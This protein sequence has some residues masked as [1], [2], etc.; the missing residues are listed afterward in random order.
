MCV[1]VCVCVFV[2]DNATDLPPSFLS[3]LF[4]FL[5]FF[6]FKVRNR[7]FF[8]LQQQSFAVYRVFFLLLYRVFFFTSIS[9]PLPLISHDPK[10]PVRLLLEDDVVC[11]FVSLLG[12]FVSASRLVPETSVSS[13]SSHP[14]RIIWFLKNARFDRVFPVFF[15]YLLSRRF[16]FGCFDQLRSDIES[17]GLYRNVD[18]EILD[19]IH[20]DYEDDLGRHQHFAFPLHYYAPSCRQFSTLIGGCLPHHF[21]ISSTV[22]NA[23]WKML[24][25]LFHNFVHRPQRWLE[26]ACR[27][28]S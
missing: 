25:A 28:I 9:P 24:V 1:C 11:V 18:W 12:L 16:L 26:D 3:F 27:I 2:L 14:N 10:Q 19:S 7:G 8:L 21:I 4:N 20:F 22:L 13:R 23:D 5:P 15:C 6:S 17:I